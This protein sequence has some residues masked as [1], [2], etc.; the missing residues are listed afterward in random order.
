M[1][2][3]QISNQN[4]NQAANQNAIQTESQA[5]NQAESQKA[6]LATSQK[7]NQATSQAV[8]QV[9]S[10]AEKRIIK[11]KTN[12]VF[13][14][15]IRLWSN[16]PKQFFFKYSEETKG[17]QSSFFNEN[18]LALFENRIMK[19]ICLEIPDIVLDYLEKRN[20]KEKTILFFDLNEQKNIKSDIMK[21]ALDIGRERESEDGRERE[22]EDGKER[23]SEDGRERESEDG[24]ERESEDGREG[25]SEDGKE[26]TI[27]LK[28]ETESD[29]LSEWLKRNQMEKKMDRLIQNVFKNITSE[30]AVLFEILSSPVFVEKTF[31]DLKIDLAGTPAKVIETGEKWSPYM[32]RISTP[33]DN[34]VW[35]A[36]RLAATA[37]L[38]LLEGSFGKTSVS[39]KAVVDYLGDYRRVQIRPQDRQ[40]IYRIIRKI[41]KIKEGEMPREKNIRLCKKCAYQ[42]KCYVKAKSIF[43]ILFGKERI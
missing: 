25:E 26:T 2:V 41:K 29:G 19:E 37:Y 43:S 11:N 6:N 21:L 32:I 22:S 36:D 27:N 16:C 12:F 15:E 18:R 20:E 24:R 3:N 39:D 4:A 7:A 30:D 10:Q 35:E 28:N 1:K 31:W 23:E 33:P 8:N 40:K 34:G 38:M 9:E 42:D 14:S 5:V 17:K 13:V